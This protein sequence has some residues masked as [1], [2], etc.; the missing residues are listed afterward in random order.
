MTDLHTHILPFTDDGATDF[1]DAL[2]MAEMAAENGT[3]IIAA[4]PH[5]NIPGIQSRSVSE[6]KDTFEQMKNKIE[7]NKIDISFV[8][9]ME[10]FAS[11]TVGEKLDRGELITLNGTRYPLI[12]FGFSEKKDFIFSV[13]DDLISRSYTPI[14]A[15][16][17]RYDCFI[18]DLQSL[19][20]LYQ[21]GVVIQIN[22]GSI[23]GRFGRRVQRTADAI[24]CHRLAA[25]AASDAHSPITRTPDLSE[26]VRVLDMNYGDGCSPL[27]LEEN[28]K[29]ILR[30]EDVFWES[31]IPFD[32]QR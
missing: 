27:L 28:P 30:N 21:M 19:Y 7:K 22:K 1:D 9:G 18:S 29:R 2:D 23:L 8:L 6:I 11:P 20:E 26:F 31:P 15:H 14:L 32:Y 16:P 24:L 17:E 12:E 4:T 25:V 5:F 3:E 10:I 13:M